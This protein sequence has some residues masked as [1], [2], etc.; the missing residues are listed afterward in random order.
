MNAAMS[1]MTHKSDRNDA[2]GIAHIERLERYCLG[3]S[4]ASARGTARNDVGEGLN[5][6]DFEKRVT[7][8]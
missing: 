4:H 3:F 8:P 7:V 5:I 2:R 1:A 6:V